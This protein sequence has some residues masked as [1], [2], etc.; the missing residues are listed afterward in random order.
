MRL[1]VVEDDRQIA[2]FVG[3]GLREA[4][5]AV[6]SV[7]NAEEGLSLAELNEYDAAVV[8]VMLPG[9]DG[10]EMI[11]RLRAE[12]IETPILILS[13]KRTVDDRVRGLRLGGDDS[14]TKPF[15][16]SELLVRLQN[17][18]RRTQRGGGT[19]RLSFSDL[20][21]DLLTRSVTR[22][23]SSIELQPRE[24]S[25]LEYFLRNPG[26]VLSK[27]MIMEHVW[28]YSFDPGSNVVDVLVFRLRKKIDEGRE[29]KLIHTVRGVGYVL[30]ED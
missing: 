1:L 4:G 20:S 15:A 2:E 19:T 23:A 30:R 18:V 28:D 7:G 16:F 5:W 9:M 13:A 11:E 14:L 12:G 8:D 26:V 3:R 10:L 25:L 24:F 22:G 27:T 29:K 17:L 6:D 21:M